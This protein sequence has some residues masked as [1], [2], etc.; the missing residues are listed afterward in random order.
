MDQT[1][2][3]ACD[4]KF[5]TFLVEFCHYTPIHAGNILHSV[6]SYGWDI[7]PNDDQMYNLADLFDYNG[8]LLP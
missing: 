6:S 1:H 3:L 5:L 8:T 2:I 7:N 4:N